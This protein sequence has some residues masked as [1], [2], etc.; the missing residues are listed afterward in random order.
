[1]IMPENRKKS[2]SDNGQGNSGK[3]SYIKSAVRMD[4]YKTSS[5]AIAGI[6]Y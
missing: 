4:F 3:N 5:E 2:K 1:M 6:F